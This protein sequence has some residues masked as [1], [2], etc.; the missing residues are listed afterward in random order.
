MAKLN[1][2]MQGL[3]FQGGVDTLRLGFETA[4]T[5]LKSALNQAQHE[6][7]AYEAAVQA[8]PREWI[9]ECE[10]GHILW[11]Q[12]Q[13]L[14]MSISDIEEAVMALRKAFVI[15]LYHHWERGARR[16]AQ[17]SGRANHQDL[18][19]AT[20]AEG[21]PVDPRLEAVLH[22]VN[23]LKHDNAVKGERLLAA[24]PEVFP[25]GFTSR[26]PRASWYEAIRLNDAQVLEVCDVVEKSGPTVDMVPGAPVA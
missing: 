3:V 4:V 13:V 25:P 16:W 15:A 2:N 5:A 19:A 23:T 20:R 26:G 6:L 7:E 22:L 8:D 9:G 12:S 11:E 17:R 14:E 24:W 21:Y 10:D 1:F 18:T